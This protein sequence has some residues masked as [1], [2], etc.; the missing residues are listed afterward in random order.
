VFQAAGRGLVAAHNAGLVHR[1]FKPDNVMITKAGQVRVMDFGL[2]RHTSDGE[3]SPAQQAALDGAA[4][5]AALAETMDEDADPDETAKLGTADGDAPVP[6]G[7]GGYLRLKLTKT[8]AMLGTPAY[9][10]PEQFA[11]TG[12]DARTD[13]FSF[14]VALYEGLYG[15]R[16]FAGDSVLAVMANVVGGTISEPPDGTRVPTWLRKILLRGL[17][18]RPGDRYP[19]MAEMLSALAHDPAKRRQRLGI[20]ALAAGLLASAIAGTAHLSAGQRALCAGG[21]ARAA[22]VWGP[23]RRR[24]VEQAFTAS[25]H[26]RA[27]Q[28][29]ANTATLID[30][31]ISRWTRM[32]GET[33]EAT[34][35]RGDQSSEVLDLRMECLD[36]RLSNVKA[37]T[38]VLTGADKA[39]VENAATAAGALPTLE[40]CAD[41]SMLRAVIRPPDDA[42]KRAEVAR[43]RENVAKVSVLAAAGR[44]DQASKLGTPIREAAARLGYKPLEAE[45]A[46]ALGRQFDSCFDAKQSL[47]DLE[48]A[49]MAAEAARHDEI[50]IQASGYLAGGHAD[51]THDARMGRHWIRH[52]EAILARFP[53]HPDLEAFLA[54]SRG[55]VFAAEGRFEDAVREEMRAVAIHESLSGPSSMGVADSINNAGVYLEEVGRFEEALASLQRAQAIYA[56][57]FGDDSGKVGLTTL[58]QSEVL[59][60]L[61]RFDEARA[62]L[63][64]ARGIFKQ[65]EAS[66]FVDGYGLLDE[67]KLE[68]AEGHARVAVR[69]LEESLLHI[70]EQDLRW[71]AD[72]H[73]A[74]ARAL[75]QSSA[76]NHK[77]ATELARRAAEMVAD[78]PGAWR[79]AQEIAAWQKEHVAARIDGARL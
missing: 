76:A 24:A 31:Y 23:E 62:A 63:A 68:L 39:I 10:A 44:C 29:F 72:A 69:L 8:G 65:Q 22:V 27:A 57:I 59:V 25:G 12:G 46:Y 53:G 45:I 35:V 77:R 71:T 36:E 7:S 33:C 73:F 19:S 16:P 70:G 18:T 14:S 28:V 1:D 34:Q 21:P 17:A 79:L 13:Q 15:H 32:Y 75:L 47:T 40:R 49:V 11:G 3:P 55:I 2:A 74:L 56:Q 9:M 43:L 42:G 4:R 78:K 60:A 54:T 61:R 41:V 50:A 64:K 38:E 51:R 48:D 30:Q 26:L 37:L 66:E 5:A 6:A 20:A 52:G 58:N 67:G